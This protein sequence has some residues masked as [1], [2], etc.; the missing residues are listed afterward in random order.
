VGSIPHKSVKF[1]LNPAVTPGVYPLIVSA[2][3]ISS[4]TVV[5]RITEEDLN[6]H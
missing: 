3:G 6:H 2:G 4:S 5:L 1:T